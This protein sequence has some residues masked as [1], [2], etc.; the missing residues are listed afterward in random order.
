MMMKASLMLIMVVIIVMMWTKTVI[1]APVITKLERRARERFY[2]NMVCVGC[3][4]CSYSLNIKTLEEIYFVS[5]VIPIIPSCQ[6]F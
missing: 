6:I 1:S 2:T 3:C 4:T 5:T